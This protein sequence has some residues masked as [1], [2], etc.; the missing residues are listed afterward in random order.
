M[1]GKILTAEGRS[2][3]RL[4]NNR[5]IAN[6][7]V[8]GS[9]FSVVFLWLLSLTEF[10][11]AELVFAGTSRLLEQK[12]SFLSGAPGFARTVEKLGNSQVGSQI[13][14]HYSTNFDILRMTCLY[15]ADVCQ[16]LTTCRYLAYDLLISC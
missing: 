15:L 9:S 14:L 13:W 8:I 5:N 16:L 10:Q 6:P 11:F 4:Y 12:L 2:C 7:G 3:V 1:A